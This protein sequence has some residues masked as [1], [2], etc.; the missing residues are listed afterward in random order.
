MKSSSKMEWQEIQ[1]ELKYANGAADCGC[2]CRETV[3]CIAPVAM[4]VYKQGRTPEACRCPG[5][6]GASVVSKKP[7][8]VP[9]PGLT[10]CKEW[11]QLRCAYDKRIGNCTG[12]E[13]AS[14]RSDG[15]SGLPPSVLYGETEIELSVY[16]GRTVALLRRYAK[17]SVEVGRLPSLLGGSFSG[18][19]LAPP[20]GRAL[21]T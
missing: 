21:K 11:Q 9:R 10:F 13:D 1:V 17:A 4:C 5:P 2:V 12:G 8:F 19:E 20:R 15:T 7:T 6:G 14:R 16:R 18:R 3:E